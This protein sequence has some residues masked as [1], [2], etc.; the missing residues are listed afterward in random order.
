M[1]GTKLILFRLPFSI[2]KFYSPG[3]TQFSEQKT[4]F[5]FPIKREINSVSPLNWLKVGWKIKK[6]RPEILIVRFWLPFMGMSLGSICRIVKLNRYT[7][8][9]SIADNII[10]HEKRPGD[11]ILCRYFIGSIDAF[12]TMSKS[13]LNDLQNS[14]TKNQ[15]YLTPHPIYD[16]YGEI[17]PREKHC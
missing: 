13:V 10:P 2:P 6:S 16:H 9:I 14:N 15:K 12:I 17:E 7:K 5:N 8:I 11:K 1:K 4:T 3:K